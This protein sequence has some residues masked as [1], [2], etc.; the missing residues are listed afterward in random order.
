VQREGKSKRQEINAAMER[1][2]PYHWI[3]ISSAP[4]GVI[5]GQKLNQPSS[6]HEPHNH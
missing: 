1:G 5:C 6:A 4:I 2:I 3:G